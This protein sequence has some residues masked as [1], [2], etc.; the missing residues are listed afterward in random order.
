MAA[1]RPRETG[2]Y[3][4]GHPPPPAGHWRWQNEYRREPAVTY[5]SPVSGNA[6]TRYIPPTDPQDPAHTPTGQ[7]QVA[8]NG[9]N[10]T[11]KP[12]TTTAAA[13]TQAPPTPQQ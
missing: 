6:P 11:H 5:V 9:S 2:D 10:G 13:P 12:T 4:A 7:Q 1:P 3:P 8:A